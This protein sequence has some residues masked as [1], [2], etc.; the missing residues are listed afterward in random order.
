MNLP[1]ANVI[2][3]KL[4]NAKVYMEGSSALLGVADIELPSLEYVTESMSGLGIAGELDTPVI[5]HFKAISL[6]LKWNT[7]NENSASARPNRARKWIRK[8]SLKST[9]S[10][11]LRAARNWWRSTS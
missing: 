6:K 2:P 3:D 1:S 9:T 8:P 4:I 5:G 7:V 10:S 11:S